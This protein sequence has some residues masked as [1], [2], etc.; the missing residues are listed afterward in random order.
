VSRLDPESG[1]RFEMDLSTGIARPRLNDSPIPDSDRI[2]LKLFLLARILR[3]FSVVLYREREA[4]RSPTMSR[5]AASGP[6]RNF[7]GNRHMKQTVVRYKT[8]P[9][10]TETN[11]HLIEQVFKELHAGPPKNLR[12]L[13][14]RLK[15]GSFLRRGR[16]SRGEPEGDGGVSR[17]RSDR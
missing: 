5:S 10:S 7:Q 8:R 4:G 16:R 9:E 1:V 12:Y 14:L 3:V 13:V 17:I 15:D 2:P 11:A 6:L